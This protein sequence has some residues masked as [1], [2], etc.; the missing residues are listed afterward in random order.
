MVVGGLAEELVTL[1]KVP[2]NLGWNWKGVR[3]GQSA[4]PPGDPRANNP[5]PGKKRPQPNPRPELPE[6]P[7]PLH[8][9]TPIPWPQN[10]DGTKWDAAAQLFEILRLI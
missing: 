2:Q 5:G 9:E 3:G 8:S 4:S 7:K 1:A 10:P 6:F